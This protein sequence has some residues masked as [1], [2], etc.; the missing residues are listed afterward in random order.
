MG[1]Q[2]EK[3]NFI[4]INPIQENSLQRMPIVSSVSKSRIT[5]VLKAGE[6]HCQFLRLYACFFLL[7]KKKLDL[8]TK[9]KGTHTEQL[10]DK[11]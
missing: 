1:T 4:H 6:T 11:N 5:S 10:H 9:E 2:I 3:K 8:V 7:I